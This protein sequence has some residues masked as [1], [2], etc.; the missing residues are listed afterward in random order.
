M[1]RSAINALGAVNLKSLFFS[2]IH[3]PLTFSKS[4]ELLLISS[5]NSEN[6]SS[7]SPRTSK[8][9]SGISSKISVGL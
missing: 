7:P 6:V 4:F 2:L 5:Y 9:S 1:F 3:N 8:S